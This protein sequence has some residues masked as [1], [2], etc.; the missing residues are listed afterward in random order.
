M[1]AIR[2][3]VNILVHTWGQV[4]IVQAWKADTVTQVWPNIL[5]KESRSLEGLKLEAYFIQ[6]EEILKSRGKKSAVNLNTWLLS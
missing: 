4:F 6:D 3:D 1:G 2:I 5:S